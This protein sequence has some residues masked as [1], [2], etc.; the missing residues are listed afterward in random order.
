MIAGPQVACGYLGNGTGDP[1]DGRFFTAP[2]GR[3][4]YRTGDL[5]WIDPR[6]GVL[7]CA[8][9][10]DHQVKLRGHRIEL[11]EIEVHLRAVPGVADAAVVPID[12]DG[13][14]DHLVAVV[15]VTPALPPAG[16]ALTNHVRAALADSLPDYA[17]PRIVRTTPALPLT[18]HGKVD[19]R[20]LREIA[21]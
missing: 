21:G 15:V 6:D 11:E 13:H 1:S 16:R 9:R 8:G 20:V 12:R 7:F 18:A 19:R 5:G 10:L 3:R 14:S 4:A 2:D 17:V